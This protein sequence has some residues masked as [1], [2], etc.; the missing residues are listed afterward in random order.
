[1]ENLDVL[2]VL[3]QSSKLLAL[4]PVHSKIHSSRE[5]TLVDMTFHFK[6]FLTCTCFATHHFIL[7][8]QKLQDL[9]F[10]Q[11]ESDTDFFRLPPGSAHFLGVQ[12][13]SHAERLTP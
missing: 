10:Q 13:V 6:G 5:E 12:R 1:M 2:L 3:A 8:Q 9:R 7:R 4:T 11:L